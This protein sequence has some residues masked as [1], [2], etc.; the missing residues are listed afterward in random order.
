MDGPDEELGC[1]E[2]ATSTASK[3]AEGVMQDLRQRLRARS[4]EVLV[5]VRIAGLNILSPAHIQAVIEMVGEIPGSMLPVVPEVV[6]Y[7]VSAEGDS[8]Y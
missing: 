8:S 4:K 2:V 5:L 7:P 1:T 3:T 6:S